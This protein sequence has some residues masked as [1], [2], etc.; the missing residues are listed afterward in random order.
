MALRWRMLLAALA[1]LVMAAAPAQAHAQ[2]QPTEP[3][4]QGRPAFYNPDDTATPA[5]TDKPLSRIAREAAAADSAAVLCEAGDQTGCAALGQ[6]FLLGEGRP[7][8]RPLAVVLL[9]EAC[10]ASV[11]AGCLTLGDFYGRRTYEASRREAA[12]LLRRGCDLGT[13]DACAR[14]ADLLEEGVP[15]RKNT[16]P[17]AAAM[18]RRTACDAGGTTACAALLASALATAASPAEENAAL[19]GLDQLCREGAAPACDVL[20]GRFIR[21]GEP[22]DTPYLVQLAEDACRSGIARACTARGR[23]AYAAAS[24]PP[25]SRAEAVALFDRACDLARE[26]CDASRAIRK[27]AD[28]AP[29]CAKGERRACAALGNLASDTWSPLYDAAAA[30]R[31]LGRA[32]ED[33]EV[34]AC[35]PAVETLISAAPPPPSLDKKDAGRVIRW[36]RIACDAGEIL[37]CAILAERLL[38]GRIVPRDTAAGFALLGKACDAGEDA[39]CDRLA[40]IALTDPAAPLP[41]ADARIAPPMD[42]AEEQ[43]LKNAFLAKMAAEGESAETKLCTRTSVVWRGVTYEDQFCTAQVRGLG[44][45]PVKIGAAP[46]Q[47]LIWRPERMGTLQLAPDDRV[48]CGGAVVRSGWIL[49]AAHC[50]SDEVNGVRY[51]IDKHGHRVRLGVDNPLADEGVSFPILRVIQHQRFSRTGLAFDIGLVQYDPAKGVRGSVVRPMSQIRLDRLTPAQRPIVARMPAYTYGWGRTAL[52]GGARPDTLRGARLELRDMATCLNIAKPDFDRRDS[53]L[54]A[55]GARGEQ[56]CFGDS[57]GPLI[58]YGTGGEAPTVIGVVSGGVKCGT[59]GVPSRF[60]RLAH[61]LVQAWL[62]LNLPGYRQ[63]RAAR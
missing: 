22:L 43:A 40:E 38:G 55:A 54:C 49:T 30:V 62:A 47:A 9:T 4:S 3:A 12:A 19:D 58:A 50:L 34:D 35:A 57:G 17:A 2:T 27:A 59:T 11:G 24:G 26:E 46:W 23:L 56:A 31:L 32:C 51:P 61:P 10:T 7:Q 42:A 5:S 14:L 1:G 16:D 63:S 18:L 28:L 36:S 53:V 39:S 44:Y 48:Q 37:Q 25:E 8:S 15:D 41:T 20:T 13:L 60:T 6:A 21:L 29:E 45:R 33:G 52:E